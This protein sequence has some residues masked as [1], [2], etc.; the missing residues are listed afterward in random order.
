MCGIVGIVENRKIVD[1]NL[2]YKMSATIVHRGPDDSGVRVS[3]D[4]K[5][6]LAHRRLSIIDLS[7]AG[8]QPMSD[9]EEKIWITYNGEIYNFKEIRQELEKKGYKFKSQTDTEVIIYAYKE[10]GI[11]CL[12]KFNG[13]FAFGIYDEKNKNIFL[14]R[15][16]AGKKP[17]YYAQYE[18]KFVFASELKAILSDPHFPKEIDYRALNFY[19]TY[20]YIPFEFSIFQHARK[21]PPAHLMVYDIENGNYRIWRYW[22]IPQAEYRKYNEEELIEELEYLLQDAVRLRLISDV[23]LGAFLSGGVDSSSVVAMM[24][25][26]SNKPVKTFSIGFEEQKYN[27]LPYAK[28]VADY[29]KTE[30]TELV[31][32]PDAFGILPELVKH[33]DEPFADSSTI[34]TY[35][36]SKMTK[37]YVT[38]A[39]SGDGG[40][41]LFGG[42]SSYLGTLGN[43]YIDSVIPTSIREMISRA[44]ELLPE[45]FVGKRQLLRLQYNPYMAFIDRMSHSYFKDRYRKKIFTSEILNILGEKYTEPEQILYSILFNSKRDFLNTLESTDFLT[46]LPEDILTKVDR[47]SMKVSLEVRCPILDYRITEFSFRK[48]NGNLKI[49]RLKKKY[50][51]KKLAKKI[52]PKQLNLN[53]KWGFAIPISNWFRGSLYKEIRSV[54]L[55]QNSSFYNKLYI[56]RL[57][58]EHINGIE[59]SGRLYAL[60]IFAI[61]ANEYKI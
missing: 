61:W 46:Y 36:V 52:L 41:E 59:H 34:P 25:R 42:Y 57:I 51:L 54:L 26:V 17:L 19:L 60:L 7:Q 11:N 13:M 55:D 1:E 4:K 37:N 38:V 31:V 58:G 56:E 10:Y 8:H 20:G 30:H 32:K 33:F 21:L 44:A 29:F 9:S 27:E 23:P 22:D 3:K 2:L 6:G 50:L 48:L 49:R 15:D 39:L 14:A 5:V 53:R 12:Q 18:N 40:D 24:C 28:I 43:Y 16:R 45:K 47:T 35:Y